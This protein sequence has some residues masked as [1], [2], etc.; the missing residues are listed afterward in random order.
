MSA[1]REASAMKTNEIEITPNGSV[2]SKHPDGV[3]CTY[4]GQ[5]RI[6]KVPMEDG[7]IFELFQERADSGTIRAEYRTE[8][9][10]TMA[11]PR[12]S[13]RSSSPS[14]AASGRSPA[15][16]VA[17]SPSLAAVEL[18]KAAVERS[19]VKPA[20]RPNSARQIEIWEDQMDFTILITKLLPLFAFTYFVVLPVSL[21][22][23][24]EWTIHY[25]SR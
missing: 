15:A 6:L 13:R 23:I 3:V 24:V 11:P 19:G 14:P 9:I 12:S 25:W 5:H 4:D 22:Y 8:L 10:T 16:L 17:I 1:N 7:S 18:D 2:I 21:A 20:L